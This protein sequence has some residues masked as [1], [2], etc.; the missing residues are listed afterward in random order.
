MSYRFL[1]V[2][3]NTQ[4]NGKKVGWVFKL[5]LRKL[6]GGSEGQAHGAADKSEK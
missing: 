6:K 3:N 2:I 1:M 4:G 5:T